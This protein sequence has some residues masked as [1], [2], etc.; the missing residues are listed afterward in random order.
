MEDNFQSKPL[1][2]VVSK[3]YKRRFHEVLLFGFIRGQISLLSNITVE[4]SII[5]FYKEYKIEE[6]D[7]P[8]SNCKATYHRMIKEF[9]ENEKSART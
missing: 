6:D 4:Q 7:Y 2:E 5:C 3:L 8:M 9:Y 1:K